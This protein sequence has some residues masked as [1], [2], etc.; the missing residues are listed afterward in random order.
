[1]WWF[2][3]L[4]HKP[5]PHRR[6]YNMHSISFEWSLASPGHPFTGWLESYPLACRRV[7]EEFHKELLWTYEPILHTT[8]SPPECSLGIGRLPEPIARWAR[9]QGQAGTG[10]LES[11][12]ERTVSSGLV[13]VNS[14]AKARG[15]P[16]AQSLSVTGR[17]LQSR[18]VGQDPWGFRASGL[19]LCAG[20]K[21]RKGRPAGGVQLHGPCFGLEVLRSVDVFL[22]QFI[23]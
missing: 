12:S 15:S 21:D 3:S 7:S 1:M 9:C 14:G 5:S 19:V 2:S 16:W 13:A 18:S 4:W 20:W 8:A 10:P 11:G 22:K 23:S 6:V 17:N